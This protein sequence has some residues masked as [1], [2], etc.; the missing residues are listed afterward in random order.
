[1]KNIGEYYHIY[2]RGAHKEPIFKDASD[3]Q[4]F[5]GLLYC[6]NN[7]IPLKQKWSEKDFWN[8][9]PAERLVEI[10]CY[11]LMPNHFHLMVIAL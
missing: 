8:D 3:Y 2:N 5:I 1:M 6:A 11:C 9:K 7:I 4:R 10:F